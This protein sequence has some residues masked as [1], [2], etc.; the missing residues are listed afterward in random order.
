[1]AKLAFRL[2]L[3]QLFMNPTLPR[4][5]ELFREVFEDEDLRVGRETTAMDVAGWDSLM[6]VRLVLEVEK[7]FHVRFRSSEIASLKN[8][9]D[10]VDL[11]DRRA[12]RQDN[13]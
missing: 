8:V 1:M 6:H 7:A 12:N 2:H 3:A 13:G 11:I 9:G 5:N 4:V 10:L